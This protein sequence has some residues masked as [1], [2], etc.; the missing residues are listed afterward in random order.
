[1]AKVKNSYGDS[2][3]P[4]ANTF[5]SLN[6]KRGGSFAFTTDKGTTQWWSHQESRQFKA[7]DNYRRRLKRGPA[8]VANNGG[9]YFDSEYPPEPVLN[10]KAHTDWMR[11]MENIQP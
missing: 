4:A 3:G 5:D 9:W 10:T 1:M 7:W 2:V 8:P 6:C 11:D